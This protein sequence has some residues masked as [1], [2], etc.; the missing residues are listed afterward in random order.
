MAEPFE[1]RPERRGV[2]G[3]RR[4]SAACHA[5]ET[6][7]ARADRV[8]DVPAEAARDIARNHEVEWPRSLRTPCTRLYRR[9]FEF[10]LDDMEL[11]AEERGDLT[12]L[13][14]LLAIDA[15]D[16]QRIHEDVVFEVYGRALDDVL[17]D[18]RL[19]PE[20]QAFLAKLRSE[21]DLPD[22]AAERLLEQ[23]TEMARQ[24]Y[25]GRTVARSNP[26]LAARHTELE[27][28]GHSASSVEAAIRGAVDEAGRAVPDLSWAEL[29]ELRA[30]V[31]EGRIDGWTVKLRAGLR[32]GADPGS[33]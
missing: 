5:I 26:L 17:V 27:L 2:L 22:D 30:D 1:E 7:L 9:F 3:R 4:K 12:H 31:R 33:P 20:E 19:D 23:R 24:R 10:C 18:N 28:T 11:S 15:E 14:A 32:R 21:L 13:R 6:L 8:R 29:A 16:A 25:L